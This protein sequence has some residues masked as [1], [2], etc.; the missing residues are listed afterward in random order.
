MLLCIL[1]INLVNNNYP[2]EPVEGRQKKV[3]NRVFLVNFV[4]LTFFVWIYYS[5]IILYFGAEFTKYYA[6]DKGA[7]IQPDKYFK[8][9]SGRTPNVP[10]SEEKDNPALKTPPKK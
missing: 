6:F 7:R 9:E 4:L 10:A 3:F 5:A 1:G 2:E 8:W